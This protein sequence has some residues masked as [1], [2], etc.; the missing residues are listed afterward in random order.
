M[1]LLHI[2]NL[3]FGLTLIPGLASAKDN[4]F[5]CNPLAEVA[6]T[7]SGLSKIIEMSINKNF[8][9][10]NN[11]VTQRSGFRDIEI[12]RSNCI[13]TTVG[14]NVKK[15]FKKEKIDCMGLPNFKSTEIGSET[16]LSPYKAK[17][18]KLGLD[19]LKLRVITPI[20]CKN[21]E[22]EFKVAAEDL[23]VSG[24]LQAEYT[25]KKE[26]FIPKSKFEIATTGKSPII[27][28][29]TAY[30]NSSTG[31]LDDL[32]FIKDNSSGIQIGA[33]SLKASIGLN[34]NFKN[35]E[36]KNNLY[37]KYFNKPVKDFET[38][39]IETFQQKLNDPKF[40]EK[41]FQSFRL[42][43]VRE[44][45]TTDNRD[46][47]ELLK[48]IDKK[49]E[50]DLGGKKNIINKLESI[51]WPN[52]KNNQE[53]GDFLTNPPP[54]LDFFPEIQQHITLS[55]FY[56]V[57]ENSGYD[58]VHTA[59][60]VQSGLGVAEF[61]HG[62]DG[63][64]SAVLQPL[65]E[66][67]LIPDILLKTNQELRNVKGY[68]KEL[69]T[70]PSLNLQNL[71]DKE[72]L[73][74]VIEKINLDLIKLGS[75]NSVEKTALLKKLAVLT[76]KQETLEAEIDKDWL[77]VDTKVL[78]DQNSKAVNMIRGKVVVQLGSFR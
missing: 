9:N 76:K 30:I 19:N 17:I 69:S 52:P 4:C 33:N 41:Q 18:S 66:K 26:N 21:L 63:V 2:I 58:N 27:F 15:A 74:L 51:K 3:L 77:P 55:K 67:E 70:V 75:G 60:F 12:D 39:K 37:Q 14:K 56:A 47:N 20:N 31:G 38:D 72:N 44:L 45:E 24:D 32:V 73:R 65:L 57:A 68:W 8:E 50:K 13:S 53:V 61:L 34:K 29:T 23:K 7:N 46:R 43:L 28:T 5:E 54:L 40:T 36:S 25:D 71:S 11:E 1:K 42:E 49:I 35:T 59:L 48:V 78:I 6:I 10:F 64:N 62:F 22:C 16:H